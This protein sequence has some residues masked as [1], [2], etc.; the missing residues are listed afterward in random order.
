MYNLSGEKYIQC[1]LKKLDVGLKL[2]SLPY[3]QRIR[4]I[5]LNVPFGHKFYDNNDRGFEKLFSNG[6]KTITFDD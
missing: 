6:W 1:A 3:T 4:K 2:I 5:P